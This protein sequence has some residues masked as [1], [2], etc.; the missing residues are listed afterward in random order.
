MT[1]ELQI[2][3]DNMDDAVAVR[4]LEGRVVLANAAAA[5]MVR[6]E[7]AEEMTKTALSA[8]WERFAFWDADGRPLRDE[9]LP[10]QRVLR[11]E[12][13]VEP[14]LLRRVV[15]ETGE[16]QWLLNKA[17]PIRDADGRL[18][19]AMS[20]TEDVTATRRAEI[21]RR[22]LLDAGRM[23]S[24]SPAVE[25]ALQDV[26]ELVV[27]TLADWCGID[28]PGNAGLLEPVA[29]A[30]VDPARVS[31]ARE[32]RRRYPVPIDGPSG[33]AAVLRTGQPLRVHG[34]TDEMLRV[35]ATNDRHL[36]LL[37]GIGLT[38]IIGVPLRV[39]DEILG[40]L[41][42]AATQVDRRLDDGD[43]ELAEAL[44]AQI[45]V[46]LRNARLFRDRDAVAHV[47]SAG[48]APDQAPVVGGC[49]VAVRY[50]PA[51]EGVEAGGDFYEAVDTPA[52]V[53]L[54]IGDVAGKGAA[55]AALSAVSRVTLRTAARLTGDAR[56]ALDELN[57]ALR[58]RD[59]MSLCTV[60]AVEMPP[61]LPGTASVLRAG[62]PPPLV[63]REGRPSAV[64]RSG[65]LLGA[66]EAADW[67]AEPVHLWPGDAL[68][69]YTDGVLDAALPDGTRFGEARL[70][71]L[72][73]ESGDDPDAIVAALDEALADL[74]LR[75][76]VAVVALRCQGVVPLLARGRLDGDA[77]LLPAMTIAGGRDAPGAARAALR[78]A[79]E[80]RVHETLLSDAV[81]IVSELVT[82]A[83]RHGGAPTPADEIQIHVAMQE[84]GLRLEVVDPGEGFEP[85]AHGPRHDGG[86]GLHLLDRLAARWGVAGSAPTI[87]WLEM[88]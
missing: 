14:L 22:L 54:F 11:G 55:A 53:I 57:H 47:L 18:M 56:A 75:D 37:R 48:L 76:D 39:G 20:I 82:N 25:E 41:L 52:G 29:I 40:T 36:E 58:G 88:R 70:H 30:H 63:V 31:A 1:R 6:A 32:L 74:R 16:Q 7:T 2:I 24:R 9:Q 42:L 49:H 81:L 86:Y 46:A 13:H 43:L 33:L 4:D 80:A 26:A 28:L 66:V 34:I 79:L 17:M 60:A 68:V 19:F 85:G 27:P 67:P 72:V 45:A 12:Q 15:R 73:S 51:G 35:E 44:A 61:E 50:R 64:G 84:N 10:W 87:V 8:L 3:V 69:L 78:T 65:P 83:V 5:A 23:L 71:S 59:E 62:H 77:E 21:G 38:S